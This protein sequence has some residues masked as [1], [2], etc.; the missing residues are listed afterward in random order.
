[1]M[2]KKAAIR[3]AKVTPSPKRGQY[4]SGKSSTGDSKYIWASA[5]TYHMCNIHCN[6]KLTRV[7]IQY[8]CWSKDM[9][10]VYYTQ[11][12]KY[13]TYHVTTQ[14]YLHFKFDAVYRHITLY[15]G[16]WRCIPAHH[17]VYR[18]ITLYTDTSRCIA[19]HH[20][21]YRHITLYTGTSRCIPAHHGSCPF[22]LTN[23]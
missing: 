10:H 17:A 14:S 1:M 5:A 13:I 4:C 16:T 9:Y 2:W 23:N 18:H 11:H 19:A 15:T 21:V 3:A 22:L 8:S 7:G 12:Y 6:T 20:A